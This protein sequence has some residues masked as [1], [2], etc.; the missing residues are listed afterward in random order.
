MS[1]NNNTTGLSEGSENG[2]IGTRNFDDYSAR[3]ISTAV[4][5]HNYRQQYKSDKELNEFRQIV[6]KMVSGWAREDEIAQITEY[7]DASQ[8]QKYRNPYLH[9]A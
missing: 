7:G 6:Y 9:A 3:E 1:V 5:R 2:T 4:S 8:L